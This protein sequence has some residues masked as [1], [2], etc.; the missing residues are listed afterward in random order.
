MSATEVITRRDLI[1]II[2][3]ASARGCAESTRAKLLA[4]ARSTDA[5]AAGWWFC[6]ETNCPARQAR[7]RNTRFQTAYDHAMTARFGR[8]NYANFIVRVV[9]DGDA[10]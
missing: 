3:E 4:V 7:V 10:A 6:G 1:A 9:D 8:P 2:D 5:V